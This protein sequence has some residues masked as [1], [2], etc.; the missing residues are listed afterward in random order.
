MFPRGAAFGLLISRRISS[1]AMTLPLAVFFLA[2]CKE[3]TPPPPPPP[4]VEVF[5]VEQRDVPIYG[6]AVGTIQADVNATISAQ[7]SGYLLSRNYVEGTSV[8][9]GQVLFQIDDRIYK[10]E[11][12]KAEARVVKTKMD[13]DR[14]T[15]LAKTQAI[16][17]QELDDAIQANLAAVAAA[18]QARLNYEFCRITSPVD[19]VAGL[20]LAQVGDLVGPNT[21]ELTSVTTVHPIRVYFSVAQQLMTQIMEERMAEGREF[22]PTNG[23]PLELTL[24]TGTVYPQQGR[25][26][27]KDNQVD[28]KTG[29]VRMVGE[30]PNPERLLIPGMFVRV[31]AKIGLLKDALVVPQRAVAELQ[32]R[33]LLAV[34]GADNKVSIKPVTTGALDGEMWVISGPFKP[35]DKVVAEGIQKVRDGT[36]VNPVPFGAAPKETPA[37]GA[38]EKKS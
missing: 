37:A 3:E 34:V 38:P 8:T 14:Y 25:I 24:A 5:T 30:F 35:G 16:S 1:A 36:T 7:V 32:G 13:V 28:V 6:E 33:T 2:G 11:L 17:Q 18:D 10:A 23:A 9:N 19:G 20:A 22:N 26:R 15:P 31:R 12:D 21:G 4:T 29:T 27:F